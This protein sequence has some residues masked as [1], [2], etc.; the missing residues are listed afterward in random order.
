MNNPEKLLKSKV[1][2]YNHEK[3]WK[4]RSFV[5]DPENKCPKII[6]AFLLYRIK[7]SDAFNNASMGTHL[8][9]GAK[10]KTPPVFPHGLNGIIVSHNAV[11]GENCTI[12]HQVTIGGRKG[13]YPTIGD[14]CNIGP[15][16]KILGGVHIGNNVKIGANSVIVE[17]IPDNAVVV[18]EKPRIIIK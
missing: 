5:I 14:N 8:N 7:R 15:G 11:I 1:Q 3:Y 18:V 6:K 10:F 4:N 2:R 16:V 9:Y 12:F 17:D 13:G